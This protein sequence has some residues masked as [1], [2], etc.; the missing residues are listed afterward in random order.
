MLLME[1]GDGILFALALRL[2]NC[3]VNVMNPQTGYT[4][5]T[6]VVLHGNASM[7]EVVLSSAQHI[8]KYRDKG[9]GHPPLPWVVEEGNESIVRLLLTHAKIDVDAKDVKYDRCALS[10]VAQSG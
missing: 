7:V 10:W 1:Y 9:P 4:P 8:V 2:L 6:Y 3:T 5:L